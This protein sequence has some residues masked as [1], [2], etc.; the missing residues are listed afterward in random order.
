VHGLL[1]T[2]TN[3]VSAL[4]GQ[5]LDVVVLGPEKGGWK[6]GP[7]VTTA[8]V[9]VVVVVKNPYTWLDS[10]YRWELYRQRTQ[11]QTLAQFVS[12]PVSHPELARVWGARDPI[13]AW[14]K[15]TASWL[16]AAL[17]GDVLVVRYEDVIGDLGRVLDRFT[18]RF[19]TRRR[20]RRPVDIDYRVGPG[21]RKVGPV[22]RDRYRPDRPV[23]MDEEVRGLVLGRLDS[24][25]VR[26]LGY[27]AGDDLGPRVS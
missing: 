23:E 8:G 24:G 9:T 10:F 4:L 22:D 20:H 5:N 26:A 6:H 2:G 7:I 25:L 12:S 14:N 16:A 13:D 11:A 21:S 27:P 3:Y 17:E 1:R 18:A 15:A 19:P